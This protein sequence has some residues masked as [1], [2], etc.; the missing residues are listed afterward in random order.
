MKRTAENRL[1]LGATHGDVDAFLTENTYYDPDAEVTSGDLY[2]AFEVWCEAH[3]LDVVGK[4]QDFRIMLFARL[5]QRG[6]EPKETRDGNYVPI[7]SGK[8]RLVGF[9][10]G[11]PPQPQ[12]ESDTLP[13]NVLVFRPPTGQ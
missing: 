13:N 4:T 3:E 5:S 2:D 8:A 6:G 11:L 9:R 10:L 1:W 12:Q 7:Q